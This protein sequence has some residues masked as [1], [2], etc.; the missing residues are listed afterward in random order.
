MSDTDHPSYPTSNIKS[1]HVWSRRLPILIFCALGVLYYIGLGDYGL[2]DPWETHYGE[3]AR[4]MVERGN[5]IDPFWGAP[6][7]SGG[8][9]RERA[10]FY[11]KPPLTMWL[12]ASGMKIFGV[13]AWGVRLFFPLLALCALLSVYLTLSRLQG[14][15]AGVCATLSTALIPSFAFLSHQAVT[16]GP[17]VCVVIMAM[18]AL[19]SA[20]CSTRQ[21]LASHALKWSTIALLAFVIV[22]QLWI[23]WP[24]D[25]SPDVIRPSPYRGLLISVQWWFNEIWLV[26]R[27][28]GW[29][30]AILLIPPSGY[31]VY[32]AALIR[33]ARELYFLLFF[34]WCGLT[35]PAKGWL[36]WAPIGGALFGYL[37][38]SGSWGWMTLKRVK[39]GLLTV[40]LTGH[41]WVVAML[42]GH[43]PAWVN[44]FIYHDHINR[45]FKGVHSTDDGAFEY[46]FQWVGYGVYPLIALVPL[47]LAYA[48]N[49][50]ADRSSK[51]RDDLPEAEDVAEHSSARI[52][53]SRE[54][55]S[56][57]SAE[58][59]QY[60]LLLLLGL[61][62]LI[63]F[64][65]FTKSSTKFHHYIFPVLPALTILIGLMVAQVWRG[66]FKPGFKAVL[67]ACLILIWVGLDLNTPSRAPS[68]GAQSWI[69]LFTYKYDRKWPVHPTEPELSALEFDAASKAWRSTLSLPLNQVS[70]RA[71]SD[72][73]DQA[74][75][76]RDWNDALTTPIQALTILAL[77]GLISLGLRSLKARR[78]GVGLIG[79]ATALA[80]HFALHIYLPKVAPHW[81]QWQLWDH[82]YQRCGHYDQSA[83][84]EREF[85][86][87]LLTFSSRVPAQLNALPAW[88]RAPVI[89]FRMN[90]RGEAFYTHNTVV[91]ALYTKD[92]KPILQNWG[93]W[94]NWKAGKRFF[95]FTERSRIKS[96]LE[97]SLPK[98]LKGQYREVFGEGRRFVLLE[99]DPD[100]S[101]E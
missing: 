19:I 21:E 78:V 72:K 10:G 93:V 33:S 79:I 65:L 26:G 83:E 57:E 30:L 82:Y 38:I 77:L 97:R 13:N 74:Y 68:Q 86:A 8:V 6:W 58:S 23:I 27:G 66:K 49:R 22:A 32:R 52:S 64:A 20:F 5:Y 55:A 75:Q 29:I 47:A 42:G 53:I 39:L 94:D 24:M 56:S 88:C 67:A 37:L 80:C 81:S 16:D 101:F 18:M 15:A 99:V 92:L 76:D 54:G 28:K 31:L 70:L 11:S 62:A 71:H 96:E 89:A 14:V 90:W 2:F 9:K 7:D 35:V 41:I 84:N 25:R 4:D 1:G 48:M 45:L 17:M 60:K 44:R 85:R 12:M 43:H 98:H 69:N 63:G 100:K 61:W 3:V 34:I 59:P 50:S 73:L 91:P 36:G 40:F 95:I 46:F 51:R 87:H